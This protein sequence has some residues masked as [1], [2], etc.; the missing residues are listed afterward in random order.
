[1]EIF[2]KKGKITFVQLYVD[3]PHT[4]YTQPFKHPVSGALVTC[5]LSHPNHQGAVRNRAFAYLRTMEEIRD[6]MVIQLSCRMEQVVRLEGDNIPAVVTPR[7]YVSLSALHKLIQ[8]H[9]LF[10]PFKDRPDGSGLMSTLRDVTQYLTGILADGLRESFRIGMYNP[11]WKAFQAELALEELLYGHPLSLLD[12]VLSASLGTSTNNTR[13]L[14]YERGFIGL[15][16]H[17]SASCEESPP[18]L[19]HW[20]RDELQKVRIQRLW[21]LCQALQ[22]GPAVLGVALIKVLLGDLYKRNVQLPWS[23]LKAT[24][25]PGRLTGALTVQQLAKDLAT[26][27]SFPVPNT[28]HEGMPTGKGDWPGCG[29]MPDPRLSR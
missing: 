25:P 6:N 26:K 3:S 2:S 28:F 4:H 10:V 12:N 19:H 21:P 13:S 15:A 18:P 22:A 9:A 23:V 5:N 29:G 8:E 20:T 1:M 27:D 16:P 14:T 17:N 11:T 7:E 24:D